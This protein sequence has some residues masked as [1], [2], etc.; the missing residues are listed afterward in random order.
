MTPSFR[1]RCLCTTLAI[2]VVAH[3]PVPAVA[4]TLVPTA[5]APKISRAFSGLFRETATDFRGLTS[6]KSLTVLAIGAAAAAAA[7]AADRPMTTTL[8]SERAGFL[9]GGETLGSARFQLAGALATFAAGHITGNAKVADVGADL[10]RANIVAQTLTGAVKMSVRRGRPDGTEFSFP[11]GHTSVTFASATVLQRHFGWKA[12]IP[13]YAVASYVAASRIHDKRHFFSDV[14]FG[15]TVGLVS[16]WAVTFGQGETKV[17]MAPVASPGGGG[18][19]LT[20]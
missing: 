1:T 17:T 14:A 20:W 11:S 7:H 18:L 3:I 10:V 8:S 12:G 16:G 19:S 5:P 6:K 13:A 15:A 9:D 4:Q 2:G